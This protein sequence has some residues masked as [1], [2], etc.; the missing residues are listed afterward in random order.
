M[1][2]VDDGGELTAAK[3]CDDPPCGGD[4]GGGEEGAQALFDVTITGDVSGGPTE[5]HDSIA[6]QIVVDLFTL[7]IAA[8]AAAVPDGATCFPGGSATSVLALTQSSQDADVVRVDIVFKAKGDDGST[9]VK[10]GLSMSGA[11]GGD[12]WLPTG[13]STIDLAT[14][15]IGHDSG[16]GKNVACS[17]SGAFGATTTATIV[18]K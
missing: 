14:W 10:Y 3:K 7:D 4:G 2:I 8:I 17:G 5:G 1:A 12:P 16:K 13:T 9:D 6:G 18:A 15:E 11:L